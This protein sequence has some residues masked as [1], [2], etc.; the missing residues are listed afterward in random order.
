MKG[1]ARKRV[2][3][4]ALLFGSETVALNKR[5]KTE[6]EVAELKMLTICLGVM[7]MGR[8]KKEHIRVQHKWMF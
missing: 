7:R 6:L 3:R 4:P 8:I 5:F 2:V 1:K